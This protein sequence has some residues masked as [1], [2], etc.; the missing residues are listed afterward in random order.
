[1]NCYVS[2]FFFHTQ[3]STISP[4]DLLEQWLQEINDFFLKTHDHHNLSK[5]N[6]LSPSEIKAH[7]NLPGSDIFYPLTDCILKVTEISFLEELGES[8]FH[9]M[10]ES[11]FS[12]NAND[13]SLTNILENCSQRLLQFLESIHVINQLRH[14]ER[15]ILFLVSIAVK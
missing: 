2:I 12:F 11:P 14:E 6:E 9:H 13:E 4:N 1:M 7:H 3:L 8:F 15:E 5:S 10:K